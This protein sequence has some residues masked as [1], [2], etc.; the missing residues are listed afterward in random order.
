MEE[1]VAEGPAMMQ[2]EEIGESKW[3]ESAEEEPVAAVK[4]VESL[5]I[6]KE[7]RKAAPAR[8]KVYTAVEGPVSCLLK[9]MSIH[10]N[11]FAYSATNA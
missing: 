4:V 9:S 10:A 3:D 1:S 6:G 5:T 7:K 8:A 2:D 11:I